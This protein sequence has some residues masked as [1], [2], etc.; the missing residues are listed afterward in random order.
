VVLTAPIPG[1]NTPNVPFGGAIL[2]GLRM[3]SASIR[4]GVVIRERTYNQRSART[5]TKHRIMRESR[6]ICNAEGK[7]KEEKEGRNKEPGPV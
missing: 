3:R 2:A 7:E 6:L 4:C 5:K 1:V